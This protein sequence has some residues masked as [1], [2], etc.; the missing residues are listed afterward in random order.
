[1]HLS[2]G[3]VQV[4]SSGGF[5]DSERRI[6]CFLPS[7]MD[8]APDE[9][10]SF[11]EIAPS[12]PKFAEELSHR[13]FLGALMSLGVRREMIGDIV[14][15]DNTAY[16]VVL[17]EVA[18]HVC[19]AL[20]SVKHTTVSVKRTE[21]EALRCTVHTEMRDVNTASLRIDS[22]ISAAWNL[23]RSVSKEL[24]SSGKVFVNSA[25]CYDGARTLREGEILSVRGKGRFRLLAGSR[26]TRSGRQY[27]SIEQFL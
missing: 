26:P 22:M 25:L 20:S 16:V 4:A 13:D 6:V 8:K 15:A 23:S 1:M 3:G 19:N 12:A 11:L 7:Y 14:I 27:V 17:S 5:D 2:A 21:K 24:L 9:I 18:D 10:F